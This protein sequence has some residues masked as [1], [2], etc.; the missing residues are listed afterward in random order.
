MVD[1]KGAESDEQYITHHPIAIVQI[2][3]ELAKNKTTINLSFNYGDE[4]G[5]TT[6]VGVSADKKSVYMDKSM[7]TGFNKKLLASDSVVFTKTDGVKIRW[8]SK[9]VTEVKLKDGAAFKLALPKHLY[10]FQRREFFRSLTPVS[11]PITC[12]IPCHN[13]TKD[14][15]ERLEMVLVDASLGGIGTIAGDHLSEALEVEKVFPHCAINIPRFGEL[16]TSL[17]VKNIT[18]TVMANGAKKFRVG[19]QFVGLSREEERIVQQ[20]ALHLEREALVSAQG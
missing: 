4:Q 3:K 13:P 14:Q 20:Y 8:T 6:V 15:D 11:N 12:Y 5:L 17:C 18:E 7:D 19:F 2:L 9:K 10:R 16:D 1:Q